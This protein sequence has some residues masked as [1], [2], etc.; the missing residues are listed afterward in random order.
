MKK[1]PTTDAIEILKKYFGYGLR[2]RFGLWLARRQLRK[3][4]RDYTEGFVD[5]YEDGKRSKERYPFL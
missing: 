2:R 4:K 3:E 1:E 5:G